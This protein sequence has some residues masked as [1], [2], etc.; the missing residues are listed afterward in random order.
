MTLEQFEE[1]LRGGGYETPEES[2][3]AKA[4]KQLLPEQ[5]PMTWS[6]GRII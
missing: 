2:R 5:L 6:I 3:P 4:L 1:A